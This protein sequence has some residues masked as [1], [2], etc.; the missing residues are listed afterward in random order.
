MADFGL[1]DE[2]CPVLVEFFACA[3]TDY[4]SLVAAQ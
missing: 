1:W 4:M 2:C 3:F